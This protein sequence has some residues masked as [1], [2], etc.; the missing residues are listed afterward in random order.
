MINFQNAEWNMESA[1]LQAEEAYKKD[2]VPIGAT[3]V[4]KAG[5]VLSAAHNIKESNFDPCGHAEILALREASEKIKNWR[6]SGAT[7]YVTLEP[8]PMCLSAALHARV[9]RIIFGAYDL[10]G[11]A[12]SLGYNMYKDKRLNHN[13]EIIGGVQHYKCSSLLSTF[14]REK[15]KYHS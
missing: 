9:S 14:F 12:I 2:E 5:K 7:L 6:L 3:I 11:G 10:K 1:L 4:D 13:C 15:R 8:C